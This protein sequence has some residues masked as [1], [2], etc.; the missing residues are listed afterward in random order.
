MSKVILFLREGEEEKEHLEPLP[1]LEEP[2]LEE[3]EQL[4]QPKEEAAKADCFPPLN[5]ERFAKS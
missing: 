3:E 5:E 1:P 2:S 4:S